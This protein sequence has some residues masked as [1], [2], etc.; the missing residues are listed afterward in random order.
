MHRCLL[1]AKKATVSLSKTQSPQYPFQHRIGELVGD[2][3]LYAGSL[4]A[5]I[6]LAGFGN[7]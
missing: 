4:V 5:Q 3:F 6:E 1:M 2:L 7:E